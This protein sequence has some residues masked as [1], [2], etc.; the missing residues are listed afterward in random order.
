MV[1]KK[2]VH[3]QQQHS[4]SNKRRERFSLASIMARELK[5]LGY[6]RET[7]ARNLQALGLSVSRHELLSVF[8]AKCDII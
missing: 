7:A 3:G 4:K 2:S 6:N 8:S 5:S 1:D